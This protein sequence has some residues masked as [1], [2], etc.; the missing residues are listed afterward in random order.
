MDSIDQ[1][2]ERW[3][4]AG[5]N[6]DRLAVLARLGRVTT[7]SDGDSRCIAGIHPDRPEIGT[8]GDWAGG[9]QVLAAAEAWLADAGCQRALGPMLLCPWFPYR[10]NM[11][12][13]DAE[14][15]SLEPTERGARWADAAYAI[16]ARYVSILARHEDN[17]AAAMTVAGRLASRGW[18]LTPLD[19][20]PKST[21][22]PEDLARAIHEVH[23]VAQRAFADTE[24]YCDVPADVMIDFSRP[25]AGLVDPRLS[26]V[27]RTPQG[28][29]AAFLIGLP[30]RAQPDRRWFQILTLAVAPE[31]RHHGLATWLV[32]AAHQAARRAGYVAGVHAMVRVN[33]AGLEDTTW[34]RGEIIRRY[35]L[36]GKPLGSAPR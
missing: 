31:H 27:A 25:F 6:R 3:I 24:G 11:G 19:T 10:A 35:A 15:L 20:G 26:L 23:P 12:P 16:S 22:S 14:P 2:L 4:A 9:P 1:D 18:R 5:G 29:P 7:F 32:A 8:I 28:E 17:I 34:Y 21:V 30:D 13:F 33:G 36:F